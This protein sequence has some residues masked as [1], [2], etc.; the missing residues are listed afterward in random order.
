MKLRDRL[1]FAAAIAVAVAVAGASVGVYLIV[2]AQLLERVDRDLLTLVEDSVENDAV[3]GAYKID[4]PQERFGATEGYAQIITADQ[5]IPPVGFDVGPPLPMTD[6]SL[7]VALG[8]ADSYF[9]EVTVSGVRLRTFTVQVADGVA[10]QAAMP[11]EDVDDTL[12]TLAWV[13]ASITA[14][15]IVVAALLGRG[16]ARAALAPLARLTATAEHVA[17]T[18]DLKSRIEETGSD[19]LGRLATS[20]N[21]M[22]EALERSVAAQKRLVADASH[23]LRTPLTS[24]RTNIELLARADHM[25]IDERKKLLADV[26]VQLEELSILVSDVVDL[27]RGHQAD[28]LLED[29]RLDELVTESI[30]RTKRGPEHPLIVARTEPTTA[31]ADRA[32]LSRAIRNL[33]DNAI[34]YSPPGEAIDVVVANGCISVRDRGSGISDE[35]RP[36]IF[37]RF[38]RSPDARGLPGSGLGLAIVRQIVLAHDG[39]VSVERPDGPGA[40]FTIQ[41]PVRE[42]TGDADLGS[43]LSDQPQEATQ[44]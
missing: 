5:I 2:R 19:E 24:V 4:I 3:T 27:A 40:L 9:S 42:A 18:E 25:P 36:R 17:L 35:D 43:T 16:V 12:G 6:R 28:L 31:L 29:V 38:Y 1:T 37:D 15:G 8:Q 39:A 11:L 7:A 14:A 21:A 30:E 10:I 26:T 33:L 22:L 41:L 44:S 34:K 20:F 32:L 23:E 13:L